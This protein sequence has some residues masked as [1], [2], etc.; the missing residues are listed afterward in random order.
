MI[1]TP[2]QDHTAGLTYPLVLKVLDTG[3]MLQIGFT[4]TKI[5]AKLTIFIIV[6]EELD[7]NIF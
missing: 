7:G 3:L 6:K 4:Q 2:S 1:S 5:K